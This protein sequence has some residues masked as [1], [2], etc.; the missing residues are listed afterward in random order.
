MQITP[1]DFIG[2]V[3]IVPTPATPDANH[4][5]TTYSVNLVETE[6]MTRIVVEAGTDI[7]MTTGTFGECASLSERELIDFVNCVVETAAGRRPVFAGVTCLNMRETISRGRAL[8]DRGADGLFVGRPMWLAMDEQAIV[9]YYR[10]IA[11][12]LPGVPLVVYDNPIA[13]KGKIGTDAYRAL[14]D[15]PEVIAAKHVGG[16]SLEGDAL[17]VGEKCRILPMVSDWLRVARL[18]PSL[19]QAAWTGSIACAPAPLVALAREIRD[20]NWDAAETISEKC[21]WAEAAMFA[22]ADLAKFMDYSIQI[23]HLRFASAGLIDPGPPRPP[24]LELPESF[25][26]G[27][28]ECGRR[29]ARLQGEYAARLSIKE[30]TIK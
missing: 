30:A 15:I 8:V 6:K 5:S 2:L 29:W 24:Y 10:D 21:R 27:A 23:G 9:Q 20:R 26:D 3:G 11:A 22:G 1:R 12:A 17:A 13:F 14:A 18:H 16:P 28:L 19:M 25:Q 7:L 4:W